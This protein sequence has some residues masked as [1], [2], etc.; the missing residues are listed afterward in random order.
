MTVYVCILCVFFPPRSICIAFFLVVSK[1]LGVL[2]M[3]NRHS[4]RALERL[5]T[6]IFFAV[7]QAFSCCAT[8]LGVSFSCTR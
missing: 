5:P 8:D 7:L 1:H 6:F 3:G 4:L 2:L